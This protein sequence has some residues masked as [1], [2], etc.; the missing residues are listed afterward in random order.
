MFQ[1]VYLD[2]P[3][4]GNGAYWTLLPEGQE[5]VQRCIKLFSTLQPPV[6]DELASAQFPV[7]SSSSTHTVRSRGQFVPARMSSSTVEVKTTDQ[8]D[9]PLESHSRA[10]SQ[11]DSSFGKE[12]LF[13]S[14][15]PSIQPFN[16]GSLLPS[17]PSIAPV[18]VSSY[19]DTSTTTLLDSSFLTENSSL[20][21]E[22]DINTISLS[23]FF[24]PLLHFAN[25]IHTT[26]PLQDAKQHPPNHTAPYYGIQLQAASVQPNSF[27]SWLALDP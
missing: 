12:N 13:R 8:R 11:F 27:S 18:G 3:R 17:N 15:P 20:M 7:P 21:Q 16:P 25:S 6:I 19:H 22:V 2:P 4:R 5:E 10:I 23:P 14:H 9:H 24:C 26:P 1:K